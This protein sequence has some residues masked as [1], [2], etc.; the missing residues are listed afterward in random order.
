MSLPP[1][2]TN[3]PILHGPIN[4]GALSL[5]YR[6]I[7]ADNEISEPGATKT[8]FRLQISGLTSFFAR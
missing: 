8:L 3:F 7:L 5:E 6:P 4:D 1:Q 2:A